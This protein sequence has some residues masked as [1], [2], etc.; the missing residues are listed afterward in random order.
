M[1]FS[2]ITGKIEVKPQQDLPVVSLADVDWGG[3]L[4]GT[5]HAKMTPLGRPRFPVGK[6]SSPGVMQ[7]SVDGGSWITV[8]HARSKGG[9]RLVDARSPSRTRRRL[10]KQVAFKLEV[11]DV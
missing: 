4:S 8:S 10:H 9:L 6:T 7:V 3:S 11:R 2:F 1:S 5:F